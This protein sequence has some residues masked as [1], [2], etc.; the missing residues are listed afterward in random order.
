[1]SGRLD[2]IPGW[3][4]TGSGSGREATGLRVMTT[5]GC[6]GR[7]SSVSSSGCSSNSN[8]NSSISSNSTSATVVTVT[9]ELATATAK[10]NSEGGREGRREGGRDRGTEGR[11]DARTLARTHARTD[12]RTDGGGWRKR[13]KDPISRTD[14]GA[15]QMTPWQTCSSETVST[16]LGSIP[17]CCN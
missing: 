13:E 4:G 1:M 17:L 16:S 10:G 2:V 9:G 3:R 15:L 11:K 5:P 12:A 7:L 6:S 14:Q 8:D